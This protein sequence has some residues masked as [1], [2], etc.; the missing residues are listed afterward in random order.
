M[1]CGSIF[2]TMLG[3]AGKDRRG[4]E[5]AGF[6]DLLSRQ[7][8]IP[9]FTTAFAGAPICWE[10]GKMSSPSG[11]KSFHR[12]IFRQ[13]L[14]VIGMDPSPECELAMLFSSC[15]FML[16]LLLLFPLF[17]D[18]DKPAATACGCGTAQ[19]SSPDKTGQ[20]HHTAPKSHSAVPD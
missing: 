18:L 15:F 3:N 17:P 5:T 13:L 2:L 7:N 11:L 10:R 6:S 14:S 1:R 9:L 16:I 20:N 12:L 19:L 8:P 4:N